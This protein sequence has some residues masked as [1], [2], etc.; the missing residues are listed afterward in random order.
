MA[1]M[2]HSFLNL[3]KA[4]QWDRLKAAMKATPGIVNVRPGGRWSALHQAAGAGSAEIVVHLLANRADLNARTSCGKTALDLAT[5]E[6]VRKVL[7]EATLL[8]GTAGAAATSGSSGSIGMFAQAPDA[9]SEVAAA[10]KKRL[11]LEHRFLDLA[12][13][14]RWKDMRDMLD[15]Q[16][17]LISVQPGGRWSALHQAASSGSAEAVSFLLARKAQITAAASDGRRPLDVS[18]NENVKRLLAVPLA[19]AGGQGKHV[20]PGLLNST[21][22]AVEVLSDDEKPASGSTCDTASAASSS[23]PL[24]AEAPPRASPDKR[25]RLSAADIASSGASPLTSIG[26]SALGEASSNKAAATAT[27]SLVIGPCAISSCKGNFELRYGAI[28]KYQGSYNF[29]MS[30]RRLFDDAG[31][32]VGVFAE[33][34]AGSRR[35]TDATIREPPST[36]HLAFHCIEVVE[37]EIMEEIQKPSSAGAFFVLP[38]QLNGAE[39]PSHGLCPGC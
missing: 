30:S 10:T 25:P 12:K 18:T 27:D 2:E 19:V 29:D 17:D 16:P 24:P 11:E 5:A 22:K 33:G 37:G 1:A 34:S 13:M 36:M 39:Y 6:P 31:A 15:A 4:R 28:D 7:K 23:R 8:L 26:A 32:L 3:A 38:S 21:S 20:F 9:T 35:F 14:R